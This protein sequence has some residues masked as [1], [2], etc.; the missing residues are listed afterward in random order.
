MNIYC[1]LEMISQILTE[2]SCNVVQE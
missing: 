1:R 2:I